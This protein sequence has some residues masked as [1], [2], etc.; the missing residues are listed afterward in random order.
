M[1][2]SIV[3]VDICF[4]SVQCGC[5]VVT[6]NNKHIS[7]HAFAD[8][9]KYINPTDNL[10]HLLTPSPTDVVMESPSPTDSHCISICNNNLFIKSIV[11]KTSHPSID[12]V[13][14][15]ANNKLNA[16]RHPGQAV[17][18]LT[19]NSGEHTVLKN[20]VRTHQASTKEYGILKTSKSCSNFEHSKVELKTSRSNSEICD[21]QN[22]DENMIKFI[23]TKHGIQVISDIETVV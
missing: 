13:D 9:S 11:T 1:F 16:F 19:D 17:K 15:S 5:C 8:C 23:F 14:A 4:E 6:F 21:Y 7:V 22:C 12:T 20:E 2:C 10:L 3:V 18:I